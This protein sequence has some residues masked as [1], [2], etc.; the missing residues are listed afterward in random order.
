MTPEQQLKYWVK[1][2]GGCTLDGM[3]SPE[4]CIY[5]K[6]MIKIC[7]SGCMVSALYRWAR[8]QLNTYQDG[9]KCESIWD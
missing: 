9:C 1:N 5:K 7:T 3:C 8:E 6:H 2:K 4:R